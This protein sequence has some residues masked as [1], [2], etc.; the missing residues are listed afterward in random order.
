MRSVQVRLLA[1]AAIAST[2]LSLPACKSSKD[3]TANG[4]AG[5]STMANGSNTM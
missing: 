3:A 2:A 1:F 4:Q 5:S